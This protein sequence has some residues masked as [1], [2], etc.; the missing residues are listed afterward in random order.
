MS[1]PIALH[2]RIV[3]ARPANREPEELGIRLCARRDC[4]S[5]PSGLGRRYCSTECAIRDM[6]SRQRRPAP[7]LVSQTCTYDGRAYLVLSDQPETGHCR[8]A[9]CAAA[10]RLAMRKLMR[11]AS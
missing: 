5:P 1:A 6:A 3:S 2:T 10:A 7:V 4:W 9:C 8:P 11:R